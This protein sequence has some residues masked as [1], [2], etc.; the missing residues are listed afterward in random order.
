M[1]SPRLVQDQISA[2]IKMKAKGK[3]VASLQKAKTSQ[4]YKDLE[5]PYCGE[6]TRHEYRPFCSLRCAQ[7]DLSHWLNEDYRVPVI[8][9]DDMDEFKTDDI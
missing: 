7:L 6:T 4:K 8:E 2:V 9:Y 5:C 1:F 3:M